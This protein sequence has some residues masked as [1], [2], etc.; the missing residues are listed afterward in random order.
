M[1]KILKSDIRKGSCA[2]WGIEKYEMEKSAFKVG[3]LLLD[4]WPV[5]PKIIKI[6]HLRFN[7]LSKTFTVDL[8]HINIYDLT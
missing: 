7:F 3:S 4:Q 2:H 5:G 8:Y 6:T 1:V